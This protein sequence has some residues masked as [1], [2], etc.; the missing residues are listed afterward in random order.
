MIVAAALFAVAVAP[1][2]A[3]TFDDALAAYE[4]GAYETAISLFL[5]LAEQG[6]AVAQNNLAFMYES[7]QGVPQDYDEALKW[8][9]RAAE[10]GNAAAQNNLGFTYGSGRGVPRD[11]VQAHLWYDLAAAQGQESAAENRDI[12]AGRM[13]P[14]QLDEAHHLAEAWWATHPR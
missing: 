5:P 3:D 10:Q 12:V 2:R 7:G 9:R 8:Y 1:A 4:R 14:E 13:S 11:F 6:N